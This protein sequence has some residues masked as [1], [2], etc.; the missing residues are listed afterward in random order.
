V[1][2]Y[3]NLEN[4]GLDLDRGKTAA[5]GIA[6]APRGDHAAFDELVKSYEVD[7]MRLALSVTGSM[8]AAQDIYCRVFEDAFISRRQLDV[9]RAVFVWLYRILVR[10]CVEFCR[11]HPQGEGAAVSG[12]DFGHRLRSAMSAL[13]PV[14]R[15]IFEL[16]Q[17]RGLKIVTLAEI[18]N[19]SPEYVIKNLQ[20]AINHL[21]RQCQVEPNGKH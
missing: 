2:R 20:N 11:R 15:V 9:G 18:F 19:A 5:M 17:H 6:I 21:R 3:A 7:V 14:E 8:N 12:E 16:K 1:Y 13:T 4:I 10:H